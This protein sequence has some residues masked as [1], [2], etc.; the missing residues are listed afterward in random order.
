M[1]KSNDMNKY[2]NMKKYHAFQLVPNNIRSVQ[3]SRSLAALIAIMTT[4][5]IMNACA[6]V[7]DI[8]ETPIRQTGVYAGRIKCSANAH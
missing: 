6:V 1:S 4:S 3:S 5:S 8:L 2:N 7:N